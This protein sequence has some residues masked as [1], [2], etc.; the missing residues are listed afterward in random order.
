MKKLLIITPVKDSIELTE[1]TIRS[2]MESFNKDAWNYV[3]YDDFSSD[4]NAVRLDE[5]S[6]ELGFRV[7][8]LKEVLTTP[9]PNYRFVLQMAQQEAISSDSHLVIVESDV[10]VN[11]D[12]FQ[13]LQSVVR[14][15]VGLVAAITVD[16]NG[17]VNFPYLF[18][19]KWKNVDVVT[20]KRFSFCC[21]LLTNN[22]LKSYSF[23]TLDPTKNWYDVFISHKSIELGFQNILQMTNR[24]IHRPHSSRPW[25]LLKY[26]NPLKYY[27]IKYTKG[28]DKI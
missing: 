3:V 19:R 27:W 1:K 25:K 11:T 13:R 8:H 14:D 5:L 28:F 24:V 23:T 16:E 15:D 18:A 2:V 10:V 4:A 7:V 21:T 12:T 22:F 20:K 26:T 6:S 9:S 17:E